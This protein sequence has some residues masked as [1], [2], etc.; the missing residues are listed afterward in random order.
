MPAAE[1]ITIEAKLICTYASDNLFHHHGHLITALMSHSSLNDALL[2]FWHPKVR[3]YYFR[4]N[5]G[6]CEAPRNQLQ[7]KQHFDCIYRASTCAEGGYVAVGGMGG[8]VGAQNTECPI[9]AL[10]SS[11]LP[12]IVTRVAAMSLHS[13]RKGTLTHGMLCVAKVLIHARNPPLMSLPNELCMTD[14]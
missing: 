2:R 1:G 6:W 5:I 11:C 4:V 9:F 8:C 12:G 14:A 13:K 7:F 10:L 3:D